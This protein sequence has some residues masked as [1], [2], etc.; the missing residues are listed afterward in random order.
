M[1]PDAVKPWPDMQVADAIARKRGRLVRKLQTAEYRES[2]ALPIVDQGADLVVGYTDD[3]SAA[4]PYD[5]PVVVFGDHTRTLKFIDFP[6]AVGADGTQCL[7]AIE[8]LNPRYFY[9]ALR[10]LNLKGDGYARHFKLLKEKRIPIPPADEQVRIANVLKAAEDAV[11]AAEA[12]ASQLLRLRSTETASSFA[13]VG[14]STL[15]AD[16]AMQGWRRIRLG[17]VFRERKE[18]GRDGLPLAS[19]SIEAGLVLRSS[20]ERRVESALSPGEH[21]LAVCGDIAYNMMRMWQ[22]ACGLAQFDCCVSPA[23]VV[24]T[25][26]RGLHSEFALLM[27]RSPS[28]IRLLHAYSQ[29]IVD[30]RL[31]LYPDAFSQIPI[32]LPPV[33]HQLALVQRFAALDESLSNG[34]DAIYSAQLLKDRLSQDLFSARIRVIA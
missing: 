12:T 28:V 27:L 14:A 4:Y 5:L 1:S 13:E 17:E 33:D 30:D 19:V 10:S 34:R 15:S 21:S 32:N 25:P 3:V 23:Y 24:M 29:G 22:G 2:G 9:Y 31:R 6:F 26:Q 8:G 18:P 7:H 16:K 11:L 20:L